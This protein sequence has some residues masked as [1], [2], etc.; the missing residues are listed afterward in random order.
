MVSLECGQAAKGTGVRNVFPSSCR[1]LP[2]TF[3]L[4]RSNRKPSYPGYRFL[5]FR[6][7]KYQGAGGEGTSLQKAN[8]NVPLDRVACSRLD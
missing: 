5:S 3:L 1:L 6:H 7:K 8:G 2:V 4:L